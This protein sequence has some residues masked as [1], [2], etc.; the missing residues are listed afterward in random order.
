MTVGNLATEQNLFELLYCLQALQTVLLRAAENNSI[1]PGIRR[2]GLIICI[3]RLSTHMEFCLSVNSPSS[4]PSSLDSID[5]ENVSP[6]TNGSV[7]GWSCWYQA[8]LS[9]WM[10][11][12]CVLCL[13]RVMLQEESSGS[14]SDDFI[15][16]ISQDCVM[17]GSAVGKKTL[18]QRFELKMHQVTVDIIQVVYYTYL[19]IHSIFSFKHTCT[20]DSRYYEH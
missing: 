9:Y 20:E 14:D 4:E 17:Q 7:E 16:D 2:S 13:H 10:E 1:T 12:L 3:A 19:T 11:I 8:V 5:K 15:L 6:N 18:I